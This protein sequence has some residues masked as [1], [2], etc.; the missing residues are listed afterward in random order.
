MFKLVNPKVPF[1]FL[2]YR[3]ETG[4]GRDSGTKP[5]DLQGKRKNPNEGLSVMA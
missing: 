2:G 3:S 4:E 1:A 5:K